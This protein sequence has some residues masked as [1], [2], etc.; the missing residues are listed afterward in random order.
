MINSCVVDVIG[1]PA[2]AEGEWK[3]AERGV[4]FEGTTPITENASGQP[5]TNPPHFPMYDSDS[6]SASSTE[7]TNIPIKQLPAPLRESIIDKLPYIRGTLRLPPSS[8]SLFYK[9]TKGDPAARFAYLDFL[10][11]AT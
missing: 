2:E 4:T 11:R 5:A 6:E 3:G 7:T 8:F 9:I 10:Y 1:F